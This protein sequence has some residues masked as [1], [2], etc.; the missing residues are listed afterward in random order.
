MLEGKAV[1][2]IEISALRQ[3]ELR[4]IIQ[5]LPD[6]DLARFDY[7]S[8]HAP[9]QLELAFEQSAVELLGRVSSKGWPI[10]VHPDAIHTPDLWRPFGKNLCI[11]NMD[12]RKPM[13]RTVDELR[14]IFDSFPEASFCFDVGHARQVDPTMS[15][16]AAILHSYGDRLLQLHVSEVNTQSKHDPITYETL[17]ACRRIAHLIP[18]EMPIIVESRVLEPAI[19][20]ELYNACRA[21]EPLPQLAIA[22]D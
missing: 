9:S 8:F 14:F 7:R 3:E 12:K 11:E 17:L 2:A 13:G 18:E 1:N 5:D 10:V 6:L 20:N 15:G 4:P 21:F 19:E 22:G 16:A